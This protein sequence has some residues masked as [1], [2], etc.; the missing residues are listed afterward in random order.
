MVPRRE[1]LTMARKRQYTHVGA[2][3]EHRFLVQRWPHGFQKTNQIITGRV[4]L[5]DLLTHLGFAAEIL[6][7]LR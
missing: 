6:R 4:D 7:I 5:K 2:G 3:V 1:S